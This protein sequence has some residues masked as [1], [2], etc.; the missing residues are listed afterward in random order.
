MLP[1]V[2]HSHHGG[3]NPWKCALI[4]EELGIP[5]E[6]KF[7]AFED[8]K[9]EP[10]I[11]V[12]PNGRL[13]AIE[14]PNTGLT[15]WESGAIVQYLIEQYDTE[16]K[17]SYADSPN[18]YLTQQ[19]LFFQAT[20][21]GPYYGQAVWFNRYSPEKIP[22]AIDRY[23]NEAVRVTGVLDKVLQDRDWLV[24]DKCTYADLSFIAWQRRA[25][26][27]FGSDFYD[28]FPK[29]KAWMERM[30]AR[31]TVQKVYKEQDEAIAKFGP[32]A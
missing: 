19:W 27:F 15:L 29:A 3:P 13:P 18:K 31:T 6:T 7:V 28:Q 25:T 16:H 12:N 32:K 14:D 2:L 26:I 17:I 5:Y 23:K 21:Q 8:V 4:M 10:F 22:I 24:G 30:E 1:I 11:S 9:K 20:G